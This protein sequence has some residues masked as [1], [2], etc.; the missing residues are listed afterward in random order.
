M[1][2]SM[3]KFL[4]QNISHTSS[5]C[6]GSVI[7]FH[8]SGDTG[9]GIREWLKLVLREEFSFPHLDVI[10]PTAPERPYS[11]YG[12]EL[13]NVWFD[14]VDIAQ[15]VPE[16]ESVSTIC[17]E[18]EPI[19]NDLVENGTPKNK[20][21][22]GGF[23]M[24][25]CLAMHMAYRFHPQVAGCFVLSG[26]LNT[27][28]AVYDSVKKSTNEMP[29]LFY[30]HGQADPLVKYEWGEKTCNQLKSLGVTTNFNSFPKLSH[31]LDKKEL[32]MLR[33]WIAKI[34]PNS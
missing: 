31:E 20:I 32:H 17:Q 4:V 14:R 33:D 28:S 18:L 25:G 2:A 19:V 23:S 27:G 5:T 1:S 16:T 15:D 12:G 30:C 10:I 29:P 34:I 6:K 22:I 8:G 26:F 9:N 7:F 24:G 21:I 13:S 11:L 3:R